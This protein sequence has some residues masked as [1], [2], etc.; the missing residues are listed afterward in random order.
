MTQ[1]CPPPLC[2]CHGVWASQDRLIF[3]AVTGS[4]R[5]RAGAPD[6]ASRTLQEKVRSVFKTQMH[7]LWR[8]ASL[9][10]RYSGSDLLEAC[11]LA[12]RSCVLA[13]LA[14]PA[15]PP[16]PIS[17]VTASSRTPTSPLSPPRAVKAAHASPD[18]SHM[19]ATEHAD[20]AAAECSDFAAGPV[21]EAVM[22]RCISEVCCRAPRCRGDVGFY[23]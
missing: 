1:P 16:Q 19:K 21:T 9:T 6:R 2:G 4:T 18:D 5:T 12:A 14:R 17:P 15:P 11:K 7:P 8:V 20:R 23:C 22:L 3:E 10:H 13:E